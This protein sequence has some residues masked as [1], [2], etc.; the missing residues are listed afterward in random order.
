MK[1]VAGIQAFEEEDFIEPCVR[2]LCDLC[3]VV[4]VV[5]GGWK[6][7][8]AIAAKTSRDKTNEILNGLI[9]ELENLMV[10]HKYDSENQI[11]HR[12]WIWET[13][14]LLGP[15]WYLQGDGDEI[16]HESDM[17]T[18]R[19][20]LEGV[21]NMTND[22]M[23]ALAPDH[24]LF[25]N[26]L[27]H[28]QKWNTAGARFFN[29]PKDQEIYA[30]PNCNMMH[31][32]QKTHHRLV[33]EHFNIFH[34]TYSKNIKRQKVKFEHRKQDD[35]RPLKHEII[36]GEFMAPNKPDKIEWFTSM[37]KKDKSELPKY[38]HN[39]R[40]FGVDVESRFIDACNKH[41]A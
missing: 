17:D 6:T 20:T 31:N 3:D 24:C 25:W 34:P 28:C 22:P 32:G 27:V 41:Y 36:N 11:V 10:F 8:N 29:V 26:D 12:Q 4:V 33:C 16:F 2:S 13:C 37:D 35:G 21:S 40:L 7:T 9:E 30:G 18:I 1:L 5:E 15:D 23:V 19:N 14:K 39:N 38:F